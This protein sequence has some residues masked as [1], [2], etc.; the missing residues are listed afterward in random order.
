MDW[1]TSQGLLLYWMHSLDFM[2][3]SRHAFNYEYELCD[4]Y[5][6]SIYRHSKCP[7]DG[8]M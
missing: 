2:W 6:F 5:S 3:C 1:Q 7:H 4:V 8:M